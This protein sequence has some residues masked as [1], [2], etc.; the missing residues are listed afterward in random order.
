[1][2]RAITKIGRAYKSQ[3]RTVVP[4]Q[5]VP[6]SYNDREVNLRLNYHHTCTYTHLSSLLSRQRILRETFVFIQASL[7]FSLRKS[8][9]YIAIRMCVN[10]TQIKPPYFNL[11]TFHSWHWISEFNNKRGLY[12]ALTGNSEHEI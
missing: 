2:H 5:V 4:F 3:T 12:S 10:I 6:Q 1:M 11:A 7:C 9:T 8:Q